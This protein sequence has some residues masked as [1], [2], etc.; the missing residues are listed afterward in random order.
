MNRSTYFPLSFKKMISSACVVLLGAT[1]AVGCGGIEPENTD[2]S[3]PP[4][5]VESTP[6]QGEGEQE[7]DVSEMALCCF[8][9]CHDGVGEGWR[10]PFRHVNQGNCQTFGRYYCRQHHWGFNGARWANCH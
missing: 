8:V 3:Q 2:D 6:P 4:S 9:S 1:L 10:G 7:G 5:S